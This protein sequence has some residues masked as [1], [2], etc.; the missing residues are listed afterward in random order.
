MLQAL[1]EPASK[2][3]LHPMAQCNEHS[4]DAKRPGVV[5]VVLGGQLLADARAHGI[6]H[7]RPEG[8]VVEDVRLG[9]EA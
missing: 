8:V 6:E 9:G 7:P 5:V 3:P 1:A 4:K 2:A